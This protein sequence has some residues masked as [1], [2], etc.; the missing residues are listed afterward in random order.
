MHEIVIFGIKICSICIFLEKNNWF[1]IL[2][3]VIPVVSAVTP[4][5]IPDGKH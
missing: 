5:I 1:V 4:F 3:T 2:K